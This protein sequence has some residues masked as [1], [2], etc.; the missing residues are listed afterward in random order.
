MVTPRWATDAIYTNGP[1]AGNPNKLA[2]SSGYQAEGWVPGQ[3][4]PSRY[5]NWWMGL[6]GG[7]VEGLP[8][9]LAQNWSPVDVSGVTEGVHFLFEGADGWLI[10]LGGNGTSTDKV[11]RSKNRGATWS[12]AT[13]PSLATRLVTGH[14]NPN[15]GD[16]FAGATGTAGLVLRSVD[17]GVNWTDTGETD[18][19]KDSLY[20]P[21]TGRS[22]MLG[23]DKLLSTAD[24]TTW[25]DVALTN[26]QRMALG[27]GGR[28]AIVGDA[29]AI[30]TTDN[31]G[32]SVTARTSGTG[33]DLLSVV[34]TGSHFVASGE[35]G[36]TIRSEDGI[37]WE[38][39][40]S[41]GIGATDD[42]T[43]LAYKAGVV[44]AF[45]GH[46]G[47]LPNAPA[48]IAWSV[49]NG[50]SWTAAPFA[51]SWLPTAAST[52]GSDPYRV[53][54][55]ADGRLWIFSNLN[56]DASQVWRGVAF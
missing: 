45:E 52:S 2:P 15:T 35:N 3:P 31:G 10:A 42:I 29:G 49:D 14:L 26:A 13:M 9:M 41:P 47:S 50:V 1:Q 17:N 56:N 28:V 32:T 24:G 16:L 4:L 12:A 40:G 39:T 34:W 27:T 48:G 44:I 23:E 43:L 21:N 7:L 38:A 8:R 46:S 11:Y 22:L 36:T 54:H 30:W 51:H 6:V 20:E 19:G 55:L 37:T 25:A 5:L 33:D 53:A 18:G